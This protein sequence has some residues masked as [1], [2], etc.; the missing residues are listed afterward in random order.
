[1]RH[2]QFSFSHFN[3]RS[4]LTGFDLFSEL[5][6]REKFSIIG[7]S[8]TWLNNQVSDYSIRIEGYKLLRC[9]RADGR[10]GGGVAFYIDNA[11]KF[12]VINV[13]VDNIL[14][15][16]WISINIAG[17][18]VCLGSLYRP[19]NTNV[20]VA[21]QNLENILENFL[22]EY[23]YV[24][25]GGDFNIDMLNKVN[26][27]GEQLNNFLKKYGL[28]QFI[29]QPSRITNDSLTLLDLI[30]S[31]SLDLLLDT[32][33]TNMEGISDHCLVTCT[34]KIK[35]SVQ[36][37][38]YRTYRDFSDFN[39][40]LFLCDLFLVDFDFIYSLESVDDMIDFWNS[41]IL[42][43]FDI[44]AP[45]KT[46][47]ISKA[48]APWLTENLK[49]MMKLRDKA[50]LKY[51]HEKTD[52]AWVAYKDLRN[53]I[54]MSVK[55]EK[56]AY[57]DYK[58]KTEPKL[59]WKTLKYLNINNSSENTA[60]DFE[61]EVYNDFFINK[62]PN[63]NTN[64]SFISDCYDNKTFLNDD[65]KFNFTKVSVDK[66]EKILHSIKS[67]AKGSDGI[68]LKMLLLVIPYLSL[69]ITFIINQCLVTGTYPKQ[70][71]DAFVIPVPKVT[72]PSL[73]SNFR[74]ISILPTI[75][76]ILEKIIHE[77][78]TSFLNNNNILPSTQSGFRANHSTTTA[79]LHVSDELFR[80]CD[81]HKTTFLILLDY[82]KAFDTLI[83][84]TLCSKLKYFGLGDLA[85][86][87][88]YEYLSLRQ[89]KVIVNNRSSGYLANNKG[90]PQGSSLGPLLFS[91]YTADFSNFL[92]FSMSHQ[93]ADDFQLLYSFFSDDIDVAVSNIN[94]DLITIALVS[95]AHGLV[96]N[97][98][99]TE[100]LIFGKHRDTVANSIAN[101]PNLNVSL[102]GKILTPSSNC[103]NLGVF[104][105]VN[106]RFSKHV[107][108][109]IGKS[110]G[111]LKVLYMHKDILSQNVKL[112]LCDSL[113]LSC[114]SYSDTVYWPAILHKDKES[115]QKIQNA[116]L[117][118]CY[119]IRKFDHISAKFTES[120]WLNLEE[121]F[122]FHMASL[123]YKINELQTPIY[124][125][126]KLVKSSHIHNRPTR[127][128]DLYVVPRHTSALFQ[129]SFS[130]NSIT[131]Y[132]QLPAHI[133]SSPSITSFKRQIKN[134]LFESRNCLS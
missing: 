113:I 18:R 41:N 15:Q 116:C 69:H 66:V 62:S 9:D 118:F 24:L 120:K 82:S 80:A 79:L 44:H 10:K 38:I 129:G 84:T 59:F 35:K 54:N 75:S 100:L 47:R 104:F 83:H 28:H 30:V 91:I 89:Q 20:T 132:N 70:W 92:N 58:F 27:S 111:K 48:P 107:S 124:L 4:V 25:F 134:F 106:L 5:V 128:C 65:V 71:K 14:E 26:A 53:L 110:Y 130:Y 37:V 108:N 52:Q 133:K 17:K 98:A 46:V 93:Y 127:H 21:L 126:N 81:S 51:K 76:K 7:L 67:N 8:E 57:L 121:R 68:D 109:L 43:L 77:Q 119:N 56:R 29:T 31:S 49:L 99:K 34:L 102:N 125:F 72:N 42:K 64:G 88:F 55:S 60:V 36:P 2:S 87:F 117:R 32:E 114:I 6:L 22:P 97:E 16:L 122:K 96:L 33:V 45:L 19:P 103:R 3:I 94:S 63:V 115:L 86:N 40:N 78:L 101:V 23:D 12:K 61:P 39:Y 105:D 11:I 13:P 131:I 90:V 50:H 74:P 85:V 95:S 112:K 1:M 123:I 73:L